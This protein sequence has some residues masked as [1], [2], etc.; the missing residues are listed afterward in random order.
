MTLLKKKKIGFINLTRKKKARIFEIDFLRGLC[1]LL[2]VMDHFFFD[3]GYLIYDL[4]DITLLTAPD[5]IISLTEASRFYW[6]WNVRVITREIIVSLFL[7]VSGLSSN[8]S[9]DNVIRGG[10]IFGAGLIISIFTCSF[11]ALSFQIVHYNPRISI[12]FG[13]ISCIGLSLFL[14][15]LYERLFLKIDK[16]NKYTPY[17]SFIIGLVIVLLGFYVIDYFNAPSATGGF[18][19]DNWFDVII[20]KYVIGAD[21]LALF[22]FM[23]YLFIG[24]SLSYLVYK[25][26]KSLFLPL[27]N[28]IKQSKHFDKI[29]KGF[30]P[31]IYISKGVS[32][33]G[34]YTLLIYFAHQVIYILI[35]GSVLLGLGY[36]LN[37]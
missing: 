15:S 8:F 1:I 3:F 24:A 17:A 10:Q 5:W 34:R 37:I 29:K 27:Y 22:P 28:K 23:G 11:D 12:Y 9:K 7:F 18:N 25:N 35:I 16:E 30:I 14:Y 20:G 31:L 21:Y 36:S 26:K 32:L 19:I 4:F 2:M 13:A 6:S 33:S